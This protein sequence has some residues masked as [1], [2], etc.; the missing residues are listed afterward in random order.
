LLSGS[1]L[2]YA[3]IAVPCVAAPQGTEPK[4]VAGEAGPQESP[5]GRK[6]TARLP[7]EVFA[8][9]P[10]MEMP[11]VSPGGGRVASQLAID[12]RQM[13]C[14][15]VGANKPLLIGLGETE[16]LDISWVNDD[17]LLARVGQAISWMGEPLYATRVF[18]V[19]ID[20]KTIKRLPREAAGQHASD[21]LWVARDGSPRILLAYQNSIFMDDN[22]WPTVAEI[23]V[24]T[25]RAKTVLRPREN[26]MSYFADADGAVRAAIH[27]NDSRRRARLLSRSDKQSSFQEASSAD[28]KLDETLTVP[29]IFT[30]EPGKAIITSAGD[31]FE[32]VY[33]YD[34]ATMELGKKLFSVPGYDIDDVISTQDGKG[35]AG[36]RYTDTQY[37]IHWFDPALAQIQTDIDKAVGSNRTARIVSLN[38]DRTVLLVH[39]SANNEPGTYYFYNLASGR[40]TLL[41]HINSA[42]VASAAAPVK[43][44]RYK[45][46]DGVEIQAVLTLPANKAAGS[47]PMI[48]LPHGGP[49]V[50]D[51]EGWDWMTQFLANRG[52]VVLQPN[53][54]GSSGFGSAFTEMGEGEWGLKMQDDL[55]DA[56]GWAVRQGIVDAKRVCIMGGSYGGYAALRGAQRDGAT[57]RC[58][59]SYAGVSDLAAMMRYD[60]KFLY[61][62]SAKAYWKEEIS[63]FS[64][65]SPV[66]FAT[67]FSVPVL[68]M[69]GG[70]DLRVP[71]QQSREMAEKLEKPSVMSNRRRRTIIS[72]SKQT[73]LSS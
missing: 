1:F 37:R 35:L 18:S 31:G 68:L 70:K 13:L 41:A 16:L 53:Y 19:S 11:A 23:D 38:R 72:R 28:Y 29:R 5:A 54:R 15:Q 67:E 4:T 30:A 7:L 42:M 63:D 39:V 44:I 21:V 58:A 40:M 9:L 64:Q 26:I 43:T 66:H 10:L 65:I 34:L 24:S 8:K 73:E 17:W 57:Y 45:A 69:H 55:I 46:R 33:E 56:V 14:I 12:G 71:V 51:S 27:F 50:R 22:F 52:Y 59:I 3:A 62:N 61:S 49:H 32:S 60:G 6:E 25:G 20:G 36:V 47:L 2:L 48:M